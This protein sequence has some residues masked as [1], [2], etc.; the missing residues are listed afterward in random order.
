M[1]ISIFCLVV[2]KSG[3]RTLNANRKPHQEQ[4]YSKINFRK[5]ASFNKFEV[6][7]KSSKTILKIPTK[8]EMFIFC[9]V[10]KK[11][12]LNLVYQ[13]TENRQE[14][15]RSKIYLE[16]FYTVNYCPE[17]ARDSSKAFLNFLLMSE[18]RYRDWL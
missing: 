3:F 5:S 11:W 16:K 17:G 13:N 15:Q 4:H 10:L 8:A 6:A 9:M 1:G 12:N 7:E 2:E 14:Q 18:C